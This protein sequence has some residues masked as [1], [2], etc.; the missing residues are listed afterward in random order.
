MLETNFCLEFISLFF[1][2]LTAFSCSVS[3]SVSKSERMQIIGTV[4][5]QGLTSQLWLTPLAD[6]TLAISSRV[7]WDFSTA[8]S[9][10][11]GTLPNLYKGGSSHL[12]FP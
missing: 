11:D 2:F 8:L 9:V 3:I 1:G 6:L 10:S 7:V 4:K 12:P 5:G